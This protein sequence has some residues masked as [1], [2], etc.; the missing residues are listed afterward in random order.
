MAGEAT[1]RATVIG[2]G[3]GQFIK[4]CILEALSAGGFV[5]VQ[6]YNLNVVCIQRPGILSAQSLAI[7]T[8]IIQ[9]ALKIVV[10][11]V[12]RYGASAKIIRTIPTIEFIGVTA[13][14]DVS[15]RDG[16]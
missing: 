12:K 10:C 4:G 8:H 13:Q 7:E 3:A 6:V 2:A 5:E 14:T 16:V 1:I 15:E 9:T 11:M